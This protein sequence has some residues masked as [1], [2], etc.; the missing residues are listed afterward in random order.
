MRLR[1]AR[2][3]RPEVKGGGH[4]RPDGQIQCLKESHVTGESR[5]T[6]GARMIGGGSV[7][8][9]VQYREGGRGGAKRGRMMFSS[10]ELFFFF[11]RHI[12]CD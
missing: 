5:V 10:R 11:S 2:H 12:T 1:G 9:K 4:P 6:E 7:I 8:G 3:T